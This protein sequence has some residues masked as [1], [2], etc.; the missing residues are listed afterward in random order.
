MENRVKVILMNSS[1]RQ[2]MMA[3]AVF[4][5]VFL[6]SAACFFGVRYVVAVTTFWVELAS[7]TG[8]TVSGMVPL[9]AHTNAP[10]T[11][12][13]F[14]VQDM[15]G[16]VVWSATGVPTDG[17]YQAW[18]GD[19]DSYSVA[20]GDHQIKARATFSDGSVVGSGPTAV[21]VMNG[22]GATGH[23]VTVTYPMPGSYLS[24]TIPLSAV[25]DSMADY[26]DFIIRDSA[27]AVV[28]ELDAFTSDG[29]GWSYD[30]DSTSLPNGSYD[31][32]ALAWF[33]GS[34]F[35]SYPPIGFTVDNPT[36][37]I[38]MMYPTPSMAV[39]GM[40]EM[41]ASTTT[42]VGT[43]WFRVRDATGGLIDEKVGTALAGSA[44]MSWEAIWDASIASP[45]SYTITG[46]Y[47]S[48]T[49]PAIMVYVE[50]T[51]GGDGGDATITVT[52]PTEGMTVYESMDLFATTSTPVTSLYF[53]I[54]DA[55]GAAVDDFPASMTSSEG[56][57]WEAF[58]DMTTRPSGTYTVHAYSGTISS[59]PVTVYIEESGSAGET[60]TVNM[61]HP[62]STSTA[63]GIVQLKASTDSVAGLV[64]FEV[65]PEG[66]SY[67]PEMIYGAVSADVLLW[68]SD[69]DTS[70]ITEGWYL[71][72]ALAS[73]DTSSVSSGDVRFYV[74]NSTDDPGDDSGALAVNIVYPAPSTVLSGS[75]NLSAETDI[76]ADGLEFIISPMDAASG[77]TM[78][79]LVATAD[80]TFTSWN[81]GWNSGTVPNGE[82]QVV[83]Q[84]WCG[85]FM[86]ASNPLIVLVENADDTTE[87]LF[88][89][90]VPPTSDGSYIDGPVELKATS[91]PETMT[92][93]LRF[94]VTGLEP[95]AL[96]GSLSAFFDETLGAWIADWDPVSFGEGLFSIRAEAT[97][98]TGTIHDSAESS[99]TVTGADSTEGEPPAE[100][101]HVE[102]MKPVLNAIVDGSVGLV[103]VSIGDINGVS[104]RIFPVGVT[105]MNAAIRVD[106]A[107]DSTGRWVVVWD[108]HSVSNGDYAIRALGLF[109]GEVI[110]DSA[111]VNFIVDNIPTEDDDT[112]TEPDDTTASMPLEGVRVLEPVSGATVAGLVEVIA[113]TYG[114]AES[115]TFRI[116]TIDGSV[117]SGTTGMRMTNG[118]WRGVWGTAELPNE[119]YS[120][121]AV[122]TMG[123]VVVVSEK[124]FVALAA[125][126]EELPKDD[127]IMDPT[128]K[129]ETDVDIDEIIDAEVHVV[130]PAPGV[131]SGIVSLVAKD[132]GPIKEVR[133]IVRQSGTG[134]TIL[135]RRA[136]YDSARLLWSTFWNSSGFEP[137]KYIVVAVG[138]DVA[139]DEV[140]STPIQVAVPEPYETE[141][142][143]KEPITE[144]AQIP[145]DA[146]REA[147]TEIPEGTTTVIAPS[148]LSQFQEKIEGLHDE[149][150]AAGIPPEKCK[151]WLAARYRA[152]E[153]RAVGIITREECV[154]H[155]WE[156]HGGSIPECSGQS[157][158]F[159][160][161]YLAKRTEGFISN[162]DLDDIEDEVLP[163]IGQVFTF[164]RPSEDVPDESG[165][166]DIL[167]DTMPLRGDEEI[168]MRMHAS[169]A[170]ARVDETRSRRFVPAIILVDT[171]GDG[172]PDDAERRI[173]TDPTNPDSD[174]D[175]YMDADELRNGYDPLGSGRLGE[176]GTDTELA[177]VDAA[178]LSGVPIEQPKY[179]GDVSDDLS[180]GLLDLGPPDDDAGEE[181]GD[182]IPPGEPLTFTGTALPG[183]VVTLFIYSYL[184]MILTT[185]ANENGDWAYELE[186]DLV[187]GEHEVY[188][189]VTD[190]TGKVKSKSNPLA[191]FV[192]EA[193]AV[194]S[195]DFFGQPVE[196][197]AIITPQDEIGRVFN[198]YIL[199]AI[200]LILA[201]LSAGIIIVLR[202]KKMKFEDVE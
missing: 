74:D 83:A 167:F 94:I 1:F 40:V 137:G 49:S 190:E 55:T 32:V 2:V 193:A 70:G 182:E 154:A 10:A 149:C 19:W 125:P 126:G 124:I 198:W 199:G 31:V 112:T 195:E 88:V 145:I 23:S 87:G 151:D 188:V 78:T 77:A 155:L 138:T 39:S 56:T 43:L 98:F 20:D 171:D 53:G 6:M 131:V 13:Q 122:A 101:R 194:S 26:I 143:L 164:R 9:D 180:I 172:L 8:G 38:M 89:E 116:G 117:R 187:D 42:T 105:D 46:E 29:V 129:P 100:E 157:R 191:F 184:P 140:R 34:S 28:G 82:Y 33:E 181:P 130:R 202:P 93:S 192:S 109:D 62:T 189:T 136:I 66:S 96:S 200:G 95:D 65:W 201:A 51:V 92:A 102:V 108:S 24:G 37:S 64:R 35:D 128:E 166:S 27:G 76:G 103:A 54:H 15:S 165:M 159:C 176:A 170:F 121:V 41:N 60:L 197:S 132:F 81:S 123:D 79:T 91:F 47:G 142:G 147:V 84:A 52:Y 4:A 113:E 7:P 57:S 186:S 61:V 133:F 120:I 22:G 118:R 17:T 161:E 110:I 71:V 72:R 153:C 185:T 18:H 179:A 67:P 16:T 169:P 160:S 69:W 115:V 168:S 162:D 36:L 141:I 156:I 135:S 144:V 175:G 45:G 107:L 97:S 152:D 68:T 99:V 48:V 148:L 119:K 178:V 11:S 50:D 12:V 163:L 173:G 3:I 59:P 196:R 139:G 183:E 21:Y 150:V 146:V 86:I 25:T 127:S 174:G 90:M 111:H 58:W 73:T 134:T 104:F 80:S 177:P 30:W 114:W 63:S 158:E 75:V 5:V 14:D 106:A 85:T 44:G